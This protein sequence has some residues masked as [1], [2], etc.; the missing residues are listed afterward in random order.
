MEQ[1][2]LCAHNTVQAFPYTSE[3]AC[4]ISG[5]TLNCCT[6]ELP[7]ACLLQWGLP[8]PALDAFLYLTPDA[9]IS[10]TPDTAWPG[11]LRALTAWWVA[12]SAP[13]VAN[14]SVCP[15]RTAT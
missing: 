14:S 8:S 13:P 10:V 6:M 7:A 2:G 11:L 12:C 1:T 3:K 15:P 4:Q 5:A 9:V